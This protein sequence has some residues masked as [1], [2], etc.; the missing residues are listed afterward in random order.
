M[1]ERRANEE[2]AGRLRKGEEG[3]SSTAEERSR[4]EGGGRRL[5]AV[6]VVA[7]LSELF[8]LALRLDGRLVQCCV[9]CRRLH[10]V[11]GRPPSQ[12]IL[13]KWHT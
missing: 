9:S 7:P 3:S 4:E 13:A 6:V 10:R 11:H 1:V 2:S 12:R 5:T 8:C